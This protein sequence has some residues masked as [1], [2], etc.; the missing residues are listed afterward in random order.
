MRI[1]SKAKKVIPYIWW[2]GWGMGEEWTSRMLYMR[3]G[4]QR[5]R[6]EDLKPPITTHLLHQAP[7]L[8]V[9][10]LY[11]RQTRIQIPN[12]M[13]KT[14]K[15]R[16]NYLQDSGVVGHLFSSLADSGRQFRKKQS[17][18]SSFAPFSTPRR[19]PYPSYVAGELAYTCFASS[20]RW[21]K[22]RH[23][24]RMLFI[25]SGLTPWF[26]TWKKP[27]SL[28]APDMR[29][30]VAWRRRASRAANREWRSITGMLA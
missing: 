14:I 27:H 8:H 5:W 18:Q 20:G 10:G 1:N 6:Q 3:S 24:W 26:T 29:S 11:S 19:L 28:H 12:T 15:S 30:R 9:V 7:G 13:F 23:N 25:S 16:F 2:N 21:K 22:S 17:L 4:A